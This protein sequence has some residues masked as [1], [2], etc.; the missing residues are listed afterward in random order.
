MTNMDNNIIISA[1]T[2]PLA[3]CNAWLKFKENNK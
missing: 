3:I 1:K 2:A